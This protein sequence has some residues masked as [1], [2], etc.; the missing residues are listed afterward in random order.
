MTLAPAARAISA[1]C[2]SWIRPPATPS[3]AAVFSS[4][5]RSFALRQH[6][7]VPG[8]A[9]VDAGVAR[10]PSAS[11]QSWRKCPQVPRISRSVRR[12]A[13]RP[14]DAAGIVFAPVSIES[15]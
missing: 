8:R 13:D 7:C 15:E 10:R 5:S 9:A 2:A 4:E 6:R 14:R 12:T 3:R 11:I 1:M